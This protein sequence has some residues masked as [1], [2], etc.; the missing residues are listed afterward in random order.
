MNCSICVIS[1]C[2]WGPSVCVLVLLFN[3]WVDKELV[4]VFCCWISLHISGG[5]EEL[6]PKWYSSCGGDLGWLVVVKDSMFGI[7]RAGGY[8]CNVKSICDA[9]VVLIS[10]RA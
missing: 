1:I 2:C 3:E 4:Q 5:W 7:E 10:W 8:L 6:L 9:I